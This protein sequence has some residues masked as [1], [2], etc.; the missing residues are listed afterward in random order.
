M[1]RLT[2][3]LFGLCI[4][5]SCTS[6]NKESTDNNH[7]KE[8]PSEE[9][10][11]R[12]SYALFELNT[13]L[14]VLSESE[15]KMLPLLIKAAS[16]MDELFW[17]QASGSKEEIMKLAKNDDDRNYLAINYGPWDRL[18]NNKSFIDGV[19]EKAKGAEFYPK[20]MTKEEFEAFKSPDKKSLYTFIRRNDGGELYTEKYSEAFKTRLSK[21][22]EYLKQAA[23]ISEDQSLKNYLNARAEALLTDEFDAS[24]RLWLDMKSNTLDCI[25]GPI[26]NYEDHLYGNKAA[27][28]AYVLVKDKSWSKRL[29][30]YVAMLPDLQNGLPC[31]EKYKQEKAGS[32]SQLNAYDVVYYAGD[33]NAGSKTIAV[34]LPNDE[35]L[36]LEKGTRRSQLKNAMQAKY[37]KILV[38]IA[39]VLIHPSQRKHVTFPAFFGNTM[40]HEVAH[41]LGIKN[42]VNG[43]G[44]VADALKELHSPLEE[45]K[46]DILGLYMVTELFEQGE[47]DEG[48]VE[49]NY[50]TFMASIFR[51]IR[52]GASSAHGKANM[53]R[54]NYFQDMGA[55]SK[56]EDGFYTVD[57]EKMKLAME[58]LSSDILRLQ[59]D[60]DFEGVQELFDQLGNIRPELRNDLDKVNEAGIPTDIVFSQ[61]IDALGLN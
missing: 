6:E 31:D 22:S 53:V 41:G 21:A 34:N 2:Y 8:M 37:D 18:G 49:D 51:S 43:K 44:R 24:D 54:F 48:V 11:S 59:G 36:Q 20:D 13:D 19:G 57:F 1:K 4:L 7:S 3:I 60:G 58:A 39:R 38:D 27:Y 28:E 5:F 9:K 30:K 23:E 32:S 56:G 55:F 42:T 33:C 10:Y 52:F 29:E 61:G 12:A 25:I 16:I 46:A 45:G 40:F 17:E 15:R 47:I 14:S 26:E 35:T 50:V